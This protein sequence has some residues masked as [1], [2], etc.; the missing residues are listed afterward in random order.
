MKILE[1]FISRLVPN[2]A[3][4]LGS[5]C[6][7]VF[8]DFSRGYDETVVLIEN[9]HVTNRKVKDCPTNLLFEK[10]KNN[11]MEDSPI[12]FNTSRDGRI[13]KS[14][15][16]MIRDEDGRITGAL[17]LNM[18]ITD[19]ILAQ[20]AISSYTSY[21]PNAASEVIFAN[22]VQELL[23]MYL[24][25]CEASFSKPGALMSRDE[26]VRALEFLDSRG[27]FMISKAGVR[28]C[29]FFNV[30]KYTLYTYLEEARSRGNGNLKK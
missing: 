13:I 30:S 3:G 28:L 11:M 17:C 12:Y 26:K 6:E 29:E 8:H 9:G 1:E 19:M 23:E 16:T 27:V 4:F 5:N 18:D 22:D 10:F 15:S 20:N 25:Q 7:V 21:D 2:L 24:S 14:C